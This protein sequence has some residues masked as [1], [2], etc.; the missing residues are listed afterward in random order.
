MN[1]SWRTAWGAAR[2]R[3]R[4]AGRVGALASGLVLAAPQAGAVVG[5]REHDGPLSRQ[6][7]MVLTDGG[8]VCSAVVVAPD[9]VLTAAHCAAGNAERRVH[10]TDGSGQPVLVA[11]SAVAVH[12]GYV[13]NAIAERRR[14]I[15]LALLRLPQALPADFSAATLTVSGPRAG[16]SATLGGF[17]VLRRGEPRGMGRFRTADLTAVEPYGPSRILVW[18][19]GAPGTGACQ[20]DSGGPITMGDA[21]FAVTTW[22]AGTDGKGCGGL[23]QGVLLGPQ[24]AWIDGM[25]AGWGRAADWR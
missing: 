16:G 13:P 14:S 22:A 18:L 21:V 11:P 9:A 20:G 4:A 19:K 25:L 24:R 5:G 12:P 15:D 8:G 3:A 17:G 23:S 10:W 1:G 6:A 2:K 7:V